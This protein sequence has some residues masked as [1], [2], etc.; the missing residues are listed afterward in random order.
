MSSRT[1]HRP[2]AGYSRLAVR[3][4]LTALCSMPAI[5]QMDQEQHIDLRA[6][7]R[8]EG[9]VRTTD[10]KPVPLDVTVRLE[11]GEG[12]LTRQQFVASDG[13]FVFTDLRGGSYRLIVTAKGYQTVSQVVEMTWEVTPHPMVYLVP[14]VKR[15]PALSAPPTETATDLAAPKQARKEY[16][17]GSRELAGG[18]LEEAR[19]HLEMA[20]AE[21]PCYARAQTALGVTLGQQHQDAAAES[22]FNKS[23]TCDGGYLEAYLQLAVLLKGQKK[24][25]ECE[26]VLE[27]GLRQ[28]PSEW[29]LHYQLGNAKEGSGEYEVAEQEFLKAQTLNAEL[30]PAFH[31][32]LAD[33]YRDWKKYAQAR[34][35]METYLRAD[36]NG[37]FAEATRK[38]LREMQASGL[39]SSV[40]SKADPGKP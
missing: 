30:P 36:P 5:G 21:D 6:A 18:N 13:K 22:A 19:K 37:Q 8:I 4:I 3:L 12:Q 29:R 9:Q 2:W 25:K 7:R 32:R 28:F 39:V 16:E 15:N 20:V 14:L 27:Q 10:N 24:F 38:M 40:P 33:L 34:A 31:L 23:I 35:E 11:E 26:T 17:K 1:S